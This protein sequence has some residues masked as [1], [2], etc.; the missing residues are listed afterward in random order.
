MFF[1]AFCY[2]FSFLSITVMSDFF[3]ELYNQFLPYMEFSFSLL[4]K[5]GGDHSFKGHFV[6]SDA[7]L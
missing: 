5:Y 7:L 1:S 4:I 3:F 2:D 6:I